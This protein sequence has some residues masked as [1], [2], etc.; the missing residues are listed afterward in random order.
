MTEFVER[1]FRN[2]SNHEAS[3]FKSIV[4]KKMM[5]LLNSYDAACVNFDELRDF[6]FVSNYPNAQSLIRNNLGM[7]KKAANSNAS[8]PPVS[9]MNGNSV[10]AVGGPV[11]KQPP[12][13]RP[14]KMSNGI[15]GI[16]LSSFMGN[17]NNVAAENGLA[18]SL[19]SLAVG[20]NSSSA[21]SGLVVNGD[22]SHQVSSSS[23]SITSTTL[24]NGI[25]G[26]HHD[27][28]MAGHHYSSSV[29]KTMMQDR[30]LGPHIQ[31]QPAGMY[32]SDFGGP[33]SKRMTGA[34][35]SSIITEYDK[36]STGSN[37]DLLASKLHL[38]GGDS[39]AAAVA[40]YKA[41][42]GNSFASPSGITSPNDCLGELG[43]GIGFQPSQQPS[44]GASSLS[45]ATIVYPKSQIKR[46]KMIYHCKFGEFG[47][48]EG[49]FTEPSGVAVNAQN[50][51]IV[52][53]TNN[54]RIQIFDKD[55]R[56][57]FQ[58][59]ECGK[60]DGQL[61]YPNRVAAVKSSGDIIVT[62]RSPTHQ[63]QI[64]NQVRAVCEEV[65]RQHPSASERR[66]R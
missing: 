8:S 5:V 52:A 18:Q 32:Y 48:L 6:G 19:A 17:G 57:K 22:L 12:I 26:F 62:E 64:Y 33:L 38:Y 10:A 44:S 28:E 49:Q 35:L 43:M 65:W 29:S 61:L 24:A 20:S 37:S 55:G 2:V 25:N 4:E 60:R 7:L 11:S 40:T 14:A 31:S 66:V 21:A 30:K 39:V 51:I 34:T 3:L 23:S 50:D 1:L 63:V 45:G 9:R 46:Q 56:F 41:N 36:W 58:F 47:V 15:E 53:D 54:H 59:G 27:N 42:G 16:V 13:S